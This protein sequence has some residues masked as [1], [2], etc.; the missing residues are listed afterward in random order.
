MLREILLEQN[1]KASG[2]SSAHSRGIDTDG[3]YY[4]E[5]VNTQALQ[6]FNQQLDKD[7]E[8]EKLHRKGEN[9]ESASSPKGWVYGEDQVGARHHKFG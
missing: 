9:E 1:K 6:L 7:R 2:K 4:S 8:R 3:Y 5:T